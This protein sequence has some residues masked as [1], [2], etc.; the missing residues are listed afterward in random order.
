MNTLPFKFVEVKEFE[1]TNTKPYS[2]TLYVLKDSNQD[3]WS[4]KM[5]D[6]ED[7]TLEFGIVPEWYE[8]GRGTKEYRQFFANVAKAARAAIKLWQ[9][10]KRYKEAGLDDSKA[11]T[12]ARI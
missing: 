3:V 11:E 12:A 1:T 4:F 5:F 2:R 6:N 10:T 9:D 8:K 7:Q